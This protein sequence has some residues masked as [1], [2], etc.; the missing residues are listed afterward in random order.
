MALV[1]AVGEDVA[2][3]CLTRLLAG[4]IGP[5]EIVGEPWRSVLEHIGDGHAR[6]L[7]HSAPVHA[8]WSR[9]WAARALAYVGDARVAPWLVQALSDDHWRVRMTAVQ[10][11]GRLGIEGLE[12]ELLP[13][14]DDPHERV[15]AAAELALRRTATAN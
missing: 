9:T 10:T 14:V 6:R 13:L 5:R 7:D 15:R 2:V 4:E 3:T 11:V 12:A 1:A 8:Y